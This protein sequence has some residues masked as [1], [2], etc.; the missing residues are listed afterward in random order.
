[1]SEA[2]TFIRMKEDMKDAMR[3]KEAEKLGTIRMLISSL[4]NKAIDLRR[5]LTEEEI[6]D[7]LSTES[8][9]RREAIEM[10]RNG[11]REDLAEK[12]E[13]EL[14][15]IGNYLPTPLTEDEVLAMIDAAM[16][17]TGAATKKDMGKV[18]GV[19]VPQT[20]GRFDGSK[21]KD[22]VMSKLA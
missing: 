11:G 13:A 16:A 19:M 6:V 4:K 22:L 21:I 7:V 14:V 18:M 15:V 12:E 1:M 17:A 8:K 2:Q 5:E 3:A 9:K 10:Y 20:K